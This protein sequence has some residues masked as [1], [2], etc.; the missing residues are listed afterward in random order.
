MDQLIAVNE[1]QRIHLRASSFRKFSSGDDHGGRK[2]NE[3]IVK[4]RPNK[5]ESGIET[6][7]FIFKEFIGYI[8]VSSLSTNLQI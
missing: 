4:I 8:K 5:I 6:L 3:I 2:K 7:F 1:E